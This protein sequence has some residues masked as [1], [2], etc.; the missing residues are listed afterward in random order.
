MWFNG[1]TTPSISRTQF[2]F[3]IWKDYNCQGWQTVGQNGLAS[4]FSSGQRN[5]I[6]GWIS[7]VATEQLIINDP[8]TVAKRIVDAVQ[9][10]ADF[11]VA[12]NHAYS[13]VL[14]QDYD[15]TMAYGRVCEVGT[16]HF[17][18]MLE[19]FNPLAGSYGG[20]LLFQTR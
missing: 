17:Y 18:S 2:S 3:V 20:L 11:V 12:D 6:K 4:S 10:D 5:K 19:T 9:A 7:S 15:W 16:N 8:W 1:Y 14:H 13:V